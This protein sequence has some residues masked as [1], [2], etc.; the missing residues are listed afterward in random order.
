MEFV[1]EHGVFRLYILNKFFVIKSFMK[2]LILWNYSLLNWVI[3]L[4]TNST[5]T[6]VSS[7]LPYENQFIGFPSKS[8]DWF[9]LNETWGAYNIF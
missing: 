9:L 6:F 2:L 1:A 8:F 4:E 7:P 5:G 3:Q